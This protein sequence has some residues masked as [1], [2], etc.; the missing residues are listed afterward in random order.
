MWR[1][2]LLGIVLAGVL[3]GC[4]LGGGSGAGSAHIPTAKD[5]NAAAQ[6]EGMPIPPFNTHPLVKVTCRVSG[7]NASCDGKTVDGRPLQGL[8]FRFDSHGEL[9]P[10]CKTRPQGHLNNIFCAV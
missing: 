10:V 9:E 5:R 2:V 3:A 6:L 1:S 8:R 7:K 4:S